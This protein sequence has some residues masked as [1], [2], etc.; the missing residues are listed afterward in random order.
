MEIELVYYSR[1]EKK[2]FRWIYIPKSLNFH[3]LK[4]TL[5]EFYKCG[6]DFLIKNP[7]EKQ[8]ILFLS[9][10]KNWLLLMI[11]KN[12]EPDTFGRDYFFLGGIYFTDSNNW[13]LKWALP[14]LI[15]KRSFY[16]DPKSF[17]N[18]IQLEK[19]KNKHLSFTLSLDKLKQ[20]ANNFLHLDISTLNNS[21]LQK[22]VKHL[23]DWPGELFD[24]SYPITFNTLKEN[25]SIL[26]IFD[27]E[28]NK[29]ASLSSINHKSNIDINYCRIIAIPKKERYK[30]LNSVSKLLKI[31]KSDYE[32]IVIDDKGK[33]IDRESLTGD[34]QYLIMNNAVYIKVFKEEHRISLKNLGDRLISLGWEIIGDKDIEVFDLYFAKPVN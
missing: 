33:M 34:A 24:F 15:L 31:N 17:N 1:S 14:Y 4:K 12:K 23:F 9:I 16:L 30:W 20:D 5:L 21:N 10:N 3:W 32:F 6:K 28:V 25:F 27:I 22:F 18:Q 29:K 8:T 11:S 2:D 13:D 19:L 7:K 26:S